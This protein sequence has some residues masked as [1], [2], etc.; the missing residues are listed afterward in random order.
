MILDCFNYSIKIEYQ[1]IVNLLDNIS[2]NKLP[3]FTTRK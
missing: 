2:P 3:K 1:K